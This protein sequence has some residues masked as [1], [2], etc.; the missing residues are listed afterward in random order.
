MSK[1]YGSDLSCTAVNVASNLLA[2]KKDYVSP[3]LNVFELNKVVTKNANVVEIGTV[4][5]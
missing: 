4:S 5:S 3:E 1:L 2:S